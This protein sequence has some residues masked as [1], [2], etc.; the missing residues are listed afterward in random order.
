MSCIFCSIIGK[1]LPAQIRWEDSQWIA[2]DDIHPKAAT[3]VLL[4][5]KTH[6]GSLV[7]AGGEHEGLLQS[8]VPTV[9]LVARTLG[10]ESAGYKTVI[11]TGKGAGQLVD[12][13]HIHILSGEIQGV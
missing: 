2:F 7:E 4:V 12:H 13:L 10:L 11:N 5:S 1:E 9:K 6:V 3:H 8:A